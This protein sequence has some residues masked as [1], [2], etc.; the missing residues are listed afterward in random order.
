MKTLLILALTLSL[1]A[2][3]CETAKKDYDI[4][5]SKYEQGI[6]PILNCNR[7]VLNL[8]TIKKECNYSDRTKLI[9]MNMIDYQNG[10]CIHLAK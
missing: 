3:V 9:I 2:G 4:S 8:E 6:N 5:N 7:M 1:N 10:M